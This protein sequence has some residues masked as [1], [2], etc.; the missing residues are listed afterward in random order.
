[1]R[2]ATYE[3]IIGKCNSRSNRYSPA[4]QH[5][6]RQVL[7]ARGLL[8]GYLGVVLG[9]QGRHDEA[10]GGFT[11]FL[12]RVSMLDGRRTLTVVLCRT[13]S[14]S[15]PIDLRMRSPRVLVGISH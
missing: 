3:N 1:M 12:G 8:V 2:S 6:I 9:M 11:G 10:A 14:Q 5:W 15:E 4:R 7:P 13:L